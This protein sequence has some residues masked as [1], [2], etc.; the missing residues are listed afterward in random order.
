MALTIMCGFKDVVFESDCKIVV[1][2]LKD[3]KKEDRTYL[4]SIIQEIWSLIGQFNCCRFHFIHRTGNSVAH[5]LAHMAHEKP[6]NIWWESVPDQI[7]TLYT[8]D[9]IH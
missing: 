4:G 3:Q 1:D 6:N 9:L 8:L 2:R 7:N 5:G